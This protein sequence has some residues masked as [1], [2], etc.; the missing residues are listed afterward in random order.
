M[1]LNDVQL[2]RLNT[3]A[4]PRGKLTAIEG[5]NDVFF[6]IR[7]IFYISDVT[8]GVA[9]GGGG[10]AGGAC[11]VRHVCNPNAPGTKCP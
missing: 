7:R 10:Q 5:N 1:N 4:D 11:G 9:R 2:M 8:E 3:N 6:E